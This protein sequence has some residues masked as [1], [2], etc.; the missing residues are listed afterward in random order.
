M[1]FYDRVMQEGR[2]APGFA[3]AYGQTLLDDFLPRATV[4]AADNVCEYFY[5]ISDKERWP[6]ADFPNIAPPM[7][8]FFIEMKSPSRVFSR[9]YDTQ[10]WDLRY[11]PPVW[12]VLFAAT[13]VSADMNLNRPA[14]TRMKGTA[15]YRAIDEGV[16]DVSAAGG[17]WF[18]M[19]TLIWEAPR[20]TGVLEPSWLWA[21]GVNTKGE[22]V[23]SSKQ[24]M[25]ELFGYLSMPMGTNY[26]VVNFLRKNGRVAVPDDAGKLVVATASDIASEMLNLLKPALLTLVF[27]HCKNVAQIKHEIPHALAKARQKRRRPPLCRYT[28]LKVHAFGERTQSPTSGVATGIEQGYHIVRGHFKTYTPEKPLLGRAVGTYWWAMHAAGSKKVGVV[29]KDYVVEP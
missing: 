28:T 20:T 1:R 6:L 22:F 14:D 27:L 21:F 8:V 24:G 29:A 2:R 25:P 10:P 4:I 3:N 16:R 18:V 12:G 5:A 19:A 7:D 26:D 23:I 9:E 17:G 13:R 11:R 15:F